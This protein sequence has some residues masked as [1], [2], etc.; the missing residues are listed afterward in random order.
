M[1]I[2]MNRSARQK[3]VPVSGGLMS[4]DTDYPF[5]VG[6]EGMQYMEHAVWVFKK[7]GLHE[8]ESE[9]IFCRHVCDAL[10]I[11]VSKED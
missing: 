6:Q 10:D 1:L 4:W 7:S 3:D 5:G 11:G 8:S 2:S 9:H